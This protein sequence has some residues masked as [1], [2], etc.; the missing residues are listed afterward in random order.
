MLVILKLKIILIVFV[1]FGII[2]CNE[3]HNEKQTSLPPISKGISENTFQ[4]ETNIHIV[5]QKIRETYQWYCAQCH[6]I[7]GKGDGI[8]SSHVTVPPRNHTKADYLETRSDQELFNAI[9]QGGLKV[10]RA[11]CMPSWGATFDKET[12]WSLVRYIRELCQCEA[13]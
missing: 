1:I 6:G 3:S 11:P 13:I 12:I 4:K 8:N 9:N 7:T 2:G 5:T 10:G